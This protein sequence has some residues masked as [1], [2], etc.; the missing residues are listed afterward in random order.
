VLAEPTGEFMAVHATPTYR[1]EV[2]RIIH[3]AS[4]NVVASIP[5]R[6]ESPV[7]YD[8]ASFNR[9]RS[10]SLGARVLR[11]LG[12]APVAKAS[13]AGD[14]QII[15]FDNLRISRWIQKQDRASDITVEPAPARVI[16]SASDMP[17][18][19]AQ[20]PAPRA[21]TC[22]T[23]EARQARSHISSPRNVDAPRVLTLLILVV[24][25]DIVLWRRGLGV[26]AAR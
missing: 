23:S 2:M 22:L 15:S 4:G 20:P 21:E 12:F 10:V 7:A 11:R 17:I 3:R 18:S 25:A 1:G 19:V 16:A 6:C 8:E 5:V 14:L 24:L 13:R 9:C 26:T